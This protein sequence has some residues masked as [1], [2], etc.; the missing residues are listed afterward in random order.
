M[1]ALTLKGAGYG[2]YERG[3]TSFYF[4]MND[5]YEKIE[6]RIKRFFSRSFESCLLVIPSH[7]LFFV[8]NL[9][10][11][12]PPFPIITEGMSE[13]PEISA[14]DAELASNLALA[15]EVST[16]LED[17]LVLTSLTG[18]KTTIEESEGRIKR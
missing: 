3:I 7:N 10:P 2:R 17:E 18:L 13:E 16:Q 5:I 11:P 6:C 14:E 9:C 15:S 4:S 12:I 1:D 8:L